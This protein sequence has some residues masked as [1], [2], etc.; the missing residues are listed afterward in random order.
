MVPSRNLDAGESSSASVYFCDV[1]KSAEDA[2]KKSVMVSSWNPV[3][4]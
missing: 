4:S 3:G 2:P 1:L